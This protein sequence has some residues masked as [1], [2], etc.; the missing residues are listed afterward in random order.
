MQP[1]V[2]R[3]SFRQLLAIVLVQ[4]LALTTQA[5]L[6]RTLFAVGYAQVQAHYLAYLAV[7]PILLLLLAPVLIEHRH[8][9]QRLLSPGELTVRVA[10]AAIGLGLATRVAWWA[11]LIARVSFGMTGNGDPGA[12]MGPVFSFSCPPLPSLFLGII[13]MAILV[14][15]MEETVH[16]GL[17]QS[18]FVHKGPLPAVLTS[19][20]FFTVCHP[21]SSYGFV[22][23]MGIIFGA[24]LWLT[25]SLWTTIIT[26]TTYNALAQLDWRCLQGH[27]KPPPDSVPLVVPGSIALLALAAACLLILVLLRCQRAGA[28]TAPARVC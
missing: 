23:L 4:I 26:H 19:A 9:L 21:P 3:L 27:W 20:L 13:V 6:S 10:A 18:A 11:Q 25:G 14:P 2:L 12:V 7:P 16:R 22:F 5:W 17:L 15:F 28:R 24:Q 8:F 1:P